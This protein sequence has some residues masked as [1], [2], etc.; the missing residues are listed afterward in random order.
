MK[1]IKF[2]AWMKERKVMVADYAHTNMFGGLSISYWKDESPDLILM[3]YTG[4]LDKTG[5]EIYEGDLLSDG[6]G[7]PIRVEWS[8]IDGGYRPFNYTQIRGEHVEVVGNI[9]ENP[10]LL[11]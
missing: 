5:N 1:N 4:L 10:E 3:Q 8:H 9:H 7:N 11:K 2:R 6:F